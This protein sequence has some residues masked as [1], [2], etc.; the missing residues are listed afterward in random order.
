MT[1][2]AS[3]SESA[4][5]VV[6]GDICLDVLGYPIPP[7]PKDE[8]SSEENWRQTG[9]TRT[10]Y[11]RGG[12][13]LLAEFLRAA[14]KQGNWSGNF[15]E[16]VAPELTEAGFEGLTRDKRSSIRCSV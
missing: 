5:I 13:W 11:R 2:F 14:L 4:A 1:T 16:P 15:V 9:E 7:S 10:F 6:A 3:S 12:A 8:N